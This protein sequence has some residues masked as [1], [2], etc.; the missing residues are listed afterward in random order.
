[1]SAGEGLHWRCLRECRLA[2][3]KLAAKSSQG[4]GAGVD[5]TLTSMNIDGSTSLSP[6]GSLE[7]FAKPLAE[8]KDVFPSAELSRK[9]LKLLMQNIS[10]NIYFKDKDSRFILM[11]DFM[12]RRMGG[13]SWV[14]FIGKSDF[15]IFSPE[16]AQPAFEDEQ[17]IM[18]SGIPML[19]VEERE[20]HPSGQITWVSSSKWPIPCAVESEPAGSWG[21]SKDIT[22]QKDMESVLAKTRAELNNTARMAGIAEI[23][24]GVLHNIGN[25]LNSVHTTSTLLA[26]TIAK[27][28]LVNLG[29]VVA[30]LEEHTADMGAFLS[31]DPKGKQVPAYLIQLGKNLIEERK[32]IQEEC[33]Q[34]R[35][36]VEHI[37]EIVLMQ[38][39]YAKISHFEDDVEPSV[40]M[41]E[42]F[43]ISE[44]SL[45]R[46]NITVVRN[47]EPVPPVRVIRHK[48]LQIL[49]NL[50]RNAKIAMDEGLEVEKKLVLF[51]K[52]NSA[53]AVEFG[54]RDNGVGIPDGNME[55]LFSFGFTTRK[56]GHGFGL[57]SSMAAAQEMNGSIHAT[58]DGAGKGATFVLKLPAGTV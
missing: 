46:H 55:K 8:T 50:I 58:S 18:H 16:H 47:F 2:I 27:S 10:D 29:K 15:D 13:K 14:D 37:K 39:S 3:E 19:S 9:L 33:D 43:H 28:R 25:A 38:Q 56:D 4:Q 36:S 23:S 31:E 6:N 42:A 52:C 11:S 45:N 12:A 17:N 22:A 53:G 54:V 1:M 20:V 48:V 57:H 30:M 24:S 26:E 49:V 21:I 5:N 51:L 7:P 44:G 32:H 40:L 34:L 41:E 35:K